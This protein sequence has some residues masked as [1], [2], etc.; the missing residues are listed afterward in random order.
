[1]IR[2]VSHSRFGL[3]STAQQE[4]VIVAND[5]MFRFRHGQSGKNIS[6]R[7]SKCDIPASSIKSLRRPSFES[8]RRSSPASAVKFLRTT[9]LARSALKTHYHMWECPGQL[10]FYSLLNRSSTVPGQERELQH[11]HSLARLKAHDVRMV[12][13]SCSTSHLRKPQRPCKA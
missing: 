12:T 3:A 10:P 2:V 13:I 7:K 9:M 6:A 5:H 1:M 8:T 4:E 11:S